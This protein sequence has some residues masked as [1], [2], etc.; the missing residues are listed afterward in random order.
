M[1]DSSSALLPSRHEKTTTRRCMAA[2]TA[3]VDPEATTFA[4]WSDATV[5]GRCKLFPC[6]APVIGTCPRGTRPDMSKMASPVS[7]VN[8]GGAKSTSATAVPSDNGNTGALLLNRAVALISPGWNFPALKTLAAAPPAMYLRSAY[9]AP[10]ASPSPA[11]SPSASSHAARAG[12]RS[13][14]RRQARLQ[15]RAA[16]RSPTL[17]IAGIAA[18]LTTSMPRQVCTAAAGAAS[19][20]GATSSGGV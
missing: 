20:P 2:T 15:P 9:L 1:P 5:T 11:G 18:W 3:C 10:R 13:Q 6:F 14:A 19:E 7:G 16:R 4:A 8:V 17:S 12:P